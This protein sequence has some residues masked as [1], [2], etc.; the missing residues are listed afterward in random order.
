MKI[1]TMG[2]P[3]STYIFKQEVNEIYNGNYNV[4]TVKE[5]YTLGHL[6]SRYKDVKKFAEIFKKNEKLYEFLSWNFEDNFWAKLGDFQP[7]LLVLDL[8]PEI[9]FGSLKLKDGTMVTRNF[10]LMNSVPD[11]AT[12]FNTKSSDYI[13]TVAQ[14]VECF[15]KRVHEIS[16]NTKLIINGAKFPIHMSKDGAI[17][18]KYYRSVYK[19]SVNKINGY[20]RHWEELDKVLREKGFHVLEF[21]QKNSAAEVN[22]PT[23]EQWY[24]FYNQSYYTDVQSQIEVLA[25]SYNLGPTILFLD[26]DSQMNIE[27]INQEIVFLN[28]PGSEEN[29]KVFQKN[30]KA[31]KIALKLSAHD[32]ILHGNMGTFYR[33]VKRTELDTN[34]PKYKDVHYRVIP[35]KEDKKYWSNRLLVR[36]LSFTAHNKTSML[37]RNFQRDFKTL[38][39]SVV[40]NTYILEIGD[41]NLINGSY[42]TNTKNFPDYEEQVQELIRF[43][44]EKYNVKKDEIVLYGASRGGTGAFIHAALG[45]Y[46]F[47]AADPV[48]NDMPWYKDSDIHFI[49]GVREVDL[50]EKVRSSLENYK[51]ASSDGVILSSSNVGVT[52]SSHLRLPLEKVTLL[53][54]SMNLYK[55]PGFNGKTVSI[56]LSVI[57]RLLMED[58]VNVIDSNADLPVGGVVLEIK[59]LAKNAISF[60]KIENFRIRLDDIKSSS[61]LEYEKAMKN[62]YNE[63]KHIRT[64]DFFEYYTTL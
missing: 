16:P 7:E 23:G 20:N 48:I 3:A 28:V 21:N 37:G 55:H 49:E 44:S 61:E 64:D 11:D 43:I 8:F 56:Q 27:E 39:D 22:F 4:Q 9:Y 57:N 40:K 54:L 18:T 38:K 19:F 42:Y 15:E 50:T 47:V 1:L 63:Y 2:S 17:K 35:P 31:K 30:K 32:Y 5:F 60:D 14:Q 52:F 34:Y 36:M 62:I 41:I 45:N 53:D 33:F 26:E 58:N 6:L 46:K 59:H 51:R 12:I 24:Y 10:R 25:Q 13:E 29:L